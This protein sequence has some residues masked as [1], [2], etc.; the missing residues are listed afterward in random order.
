MVDVRYGHVRVCRPCIGEW[1]LR[2]SGYQKPLTIP[3]GERAEGWRGAA[4][5]PSHQEPGWGNLA[6]DLEWTWEAAREVAAAYA[7]LARA[8]LLLGRFSGRRPGA[9]G[10]HCRFR[11]NEAASPSLHWITM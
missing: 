7:H 6:A 2:G 10:Y 4:T 9:V 8:L 1:G 11:S 5:L 3:R